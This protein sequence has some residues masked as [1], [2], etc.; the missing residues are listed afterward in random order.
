MV[1]VGAYYYLWYDKDQWRDYGHVHMPVRKFYDSSDTEVISQHIQW[2][3][4]HG[5]K[6]FL[7]SWDGPEKE[8]KKI[9][10]NL[11]KTFLTDPLSRDIQF[12]IFYESEARLKKPGQPLDVMN[13]SDPNKVNRLV[14]DFNY[15]A[16]N[17][18]KDDRYYRVHGKPLVALYLSRAYMHTIRDV[19]AAILRL[20]RNELYLVGDEVYWHTI[21]RDRLR[22]WKRPTLGNRE[23]FVKLYDAVTAY[24]MHE[25]PKSA[26]DKENFDKNFDSRVEKEYGDWLKALP[27]PVGFIPN[28][29]PGFDDTKI[30][31]ERRPE[32]HTPLGR[33]LDRFDLQL[34]LATRNV[35]KGNLLLITS[36]NE[37]HEDTQIEP[38]EDYETPAEPLSY[39]K[40]LERSRTLR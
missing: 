14:D 39:L 2:A 10:R 18:F 6:F 20:R 1:D 25:E 26:A 19:E 9:D 32:K 5:I 36:F 37:W 12:A 30:P 4:E 38:A 8:G 16:E 13:L 7:V 40:A 21:V 11:R 33:S 35:S 31:A 23:E 34:Q 28:A 3:K 27:E 24:N 17:Y 22:P 29:I 15:L